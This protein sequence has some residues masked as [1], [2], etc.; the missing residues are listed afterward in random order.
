MIL[1]QSFFLFCRR[2]TLHWLIY[3]ALSQ[4]RR[5]DRQLS[6]KGHTNRKVGTQSHR[7]L[8]SFRDSGAAGKK[9]NDGTQRPSV[10]RLIPSVDL[11][12]SDEMLQHIC[13]QLCAI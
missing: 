12:V 9:S 5:K 10:E 7:S 1:R 13:A 2:I 8:E 6:D 11:L 3:Q 4:R